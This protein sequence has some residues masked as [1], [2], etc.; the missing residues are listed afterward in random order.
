MY[1]ATLKLEIYYLKSGEEPVCRLIGV[2]MATRKVA[3]DNFFS[4]STPLHCPFVQ[5]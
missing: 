2:V 1:Q 3:R 4:L 5:R